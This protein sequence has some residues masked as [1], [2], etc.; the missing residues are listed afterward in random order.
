M[1]LEEFKARVDILRVVELFLPLKKQGALFKANCPFHSERTPSFVLNVEKA[2]WHCF[3]CN[4]GGDAIKFIQEIKRLSFKEAVVELAKIENIE[5]SGLFNASE[6]EEFQFLSD[7]NEYFKKNLNANV[8][9]YLFKRGLNENDIF[10]FELGYTGDMEAFLSFL[11]AKDYLKI[12]KKLGYIRENNQGYFS[13]FINRI[14]FCIKDNLARVRGFSTRELIRNPKLGK[15]VNSLKNDFF[16]KSFL[17]FNFDK[18]KEYAKLTKKILI[19]EGFFDTIALHKQGFKEA[20]ASCGTAFTL[21]HLSLIKRLNVED[22]KL[23]FVP[24]KDEAGYES[25]ARALWLCFENEIF[26]TEVAVVK[27]NIKDIGEFL[28]KFKNENLKENLHYYDGMEFYIKHRLKGKNEEEKF[29]LFKAFEKLFSS[30]DNFYLKANLVKKAALYF[31]VEEREFL[32]ERS[33]KK[34]FKKINESDLSLMDE[35]ILKTALQKEVFKENL[36]F[37]TNDFL[38]SE[39]EKNLKELLEKHK[40]FL[41]NKEIQIYEQKE[42]KKGILAYILKRLY[43]NLSKAEGQEASRLSLNIAK[44]KREI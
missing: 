16:N 35:K 5:L 28:Q 39:E 26:N 34:D 43:E 40:S 27:K 19:C 44:L 1:N 24:D 13:L 10:E 42:F 11:K 31:E 25:V 37:Y 18:A 7:L 20:V 4:K 30:L 23:V 6:K 22:L 12:A 14:S 21:G 36:L 3:G 32:K 9:E 33:K 38:G 8:K 41:E 15:Y 29:K 17:L 2:Y